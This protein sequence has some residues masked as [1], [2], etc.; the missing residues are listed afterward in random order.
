LNGRRAFQHGMA[1]AIPP[2]NGLF[3]MA[4][5]ELPELPGKGKS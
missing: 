5:M 2:M 4:G 3:N 1:K